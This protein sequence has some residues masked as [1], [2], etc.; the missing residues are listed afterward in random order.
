MLSQL[1]A[2]GR[3]GKLLKFRR[4]GAVGDSMGGGELSGYITSLEQSILNSFTLTFCIVPTNLWAMDT[5]L[6]LNL[7]SYLHT[8][9]TYFPLPLPTRGWKWWVVWRV[10]PCPLFPAWGH[11]T[12]DSFFTSYSQPTLLPLSTISQ[13][14]DREFSWSGFPLMLVLMNAKVRTSDTGQPLLMKKRLLPNECPSLIPIE[15][16]S[17][18]PTLLTRCS[19]NPS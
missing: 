13:V 7:L 1:L 9:L 6:L 4:E 18:F 14:G 2:W 11:R 17:M 3:V 10:L 12:G 5:L 15:Y 16:L 19:C 8:G